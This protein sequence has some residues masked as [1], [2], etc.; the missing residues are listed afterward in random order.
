M[1]NNGAF[2]FRPFLFQSNEAT[3]Q[4]SA[5]TALGVGS[6]QTNV[7]P[8]LK[9]CMCGFE[10]RPLPTQRSK[11]KSPLVWRRNF[12]TI[13]NFIHFLFSFIPL[14]PHARKN[15]CCSGINLHICRD[16]RPAGCRH[17]YIRGRT[18]STRLSHQHR[19][20]CLWICL[21]NVMDLLLNSAIH[22]QSIFD[23]INIGNEPSYLQRQHPQQTSRDYHHHRTG[24]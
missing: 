12:A 11:N 14:P 15:G 24:V 23:H 18:R 20:S 5:H 4:R 13:C 2:F 10:F 8:T 3:R 9:S 1:E 7:F 6:E 17:G 22:I 21:S 16:H 19:M